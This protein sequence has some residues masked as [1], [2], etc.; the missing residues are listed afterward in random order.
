MSENQR[1]NPLSPPPLTGGVAHTSWGGR[2]QGTG[3]FRGIPQVRHSEVVN[4]YA[5]LL[6]SGWDTFAETYNVTVPDALQEELEVVR[7]EAEAEDQRGGTW[8]TIMFGGEEIQINPRR[9]K[10]GR[11]FLQNDDFQITIRSPLME[12]P[13][14]VRYGAAGLWE[15]GLTALRKRAL[16][17]LC[18][19]TMPA[20]DDWQRVT[21]AHW[22]F[23]FLS[24]A[25]TDEMRPSIME[26]V[27][28]HS[29]VKKRIRSKIDLEAWGRSVYLETLTIGS[30]KSLQ[31]QVY[32]KAK[33]ITEVNGKGWMV[34]LWRRTSKDV[35]AENPRHVWRLEIRMGKDFLR[36]RGVLR[37]SELEAGLRE[38]LAE[39]L[40]TR[41]LTVRTE[42]SNRWRWPVHSLWV[43]AHRASGGAVY[44]LP[45]GRQVTEAPDV[46]VERYKKTVAGLSRAAAVL[47]VGDY[48]PIDALAFVRQAVQEGERDP[49]HEIKVDHVREREKYAKEAR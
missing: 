2:T 12:W 32:D 23:D 33:E 41:R 49:R 15:H 48:D 35:D 44:M 42:D 47:S 21:E 10:R 11:W 38:L 20:G 40:F 45:L 29:S 16:A 46:R 24:P 6:A 9:P 43:S 13:V 4:G 14:T 39:A 5:Q 18:A 1:S 17:M 8:R 7:S 3:E 22:A 36:G 26:T 19:E 30:K 31:L 34:D 37:L 27:V 28:C 25:F